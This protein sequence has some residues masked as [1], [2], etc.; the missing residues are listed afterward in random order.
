M[1][2]PPED[3]AQKLIDVSDQFKGTGFDI[4][5][6]EVASA[7]DVPRATLYYYF[8]GRDDLVSFFMNDKLDRMHTTVQKAAASEG[9]PIERMELVIREVTRKLIEYPVL[10]MELPIALRRSDDFTEVMLNAERTVG[11]PLRELLIE[12]RALGEFDFEDLDVIITAMNGAVMQVAMM[13]VLRNPEPDADAVADKLAA[14]IIRG[15]AT[16]SPS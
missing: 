8:S 15:L 5:I 6:D 2:R 11:A 7:A 10:C 13:E 16:R 1:K 9:S 12:G 14:A 3:L 4:S